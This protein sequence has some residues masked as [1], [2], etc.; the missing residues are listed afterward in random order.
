MYINFFKSYAYL[1]FLLI[2]NLWFYIYFLIN[3]KRHIFFHY[4]PLKIYSERY[5]FINNMSF[6]Y[7]IIQ[8]K[9]IPTKLQQ[10]IIFSRKT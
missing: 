5:I 4:Y 8:Y 2:K 7:K 1:Y 9:Y 3:N 6:R 10:K